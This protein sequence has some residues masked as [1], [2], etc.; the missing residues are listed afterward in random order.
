MAAV[1]KIFVGFGFGAIQ[2]GLF[3]Y[4]AFRSGKFERLV[5]AEVVP[6]LV[7]AIRRAK[8]CYRVNVATRTGIEVR[9]VHGVEIFNPTVPA[10][11][12]A[13]A[14]A[15][16]EATEIATALPSVEFFLRGEPS[17][18]GMIARAMQ[19]KAARQ[20]LPPSIV[21]T[22][23][24]HNHAAEILQAV[25]DQNLDPAARPAVR[26]RS[27]ILN[28]VIGKMSGMVTDP[29]EI[30]ADGLARLVDDFPRALLVE[31]FNRILITRIEL[32]GFRRGIEVFIEK[33]DLLPFEEAKLYGH[34]AVHALIGYLIQRRGHRF[35]SEAADDL[36]LMA[37]AREA[38]LEESGAA[39][40]ARH[41][42]LD[43]LFTPA[44]YQ[45]YADDLLARMTN[46]YLRDHTERVIRDPRRKLAWEDRLIG[47]MRFALD[48]GITPRRFA[49]GAA[50]ALETLGSP[51]SAADQ[52][53]ELWPA[54][55]EPSGRKA[56]LIRLITEAQAKLKTEQT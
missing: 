1:P 53:Q 9:K 7:A 38:F 22:A 51:K 31:E 13:L 46:P 48:A 20:D 32:P 41:R 21:Y 18:A 29:G 50:A 47:T 5:V 19:T 14:R 23:E 45:A 43:P 30:A 37:F 28:T 12:R 24:N 15:L 44:G 52:L 39:L 2:G 4:E 26:R 42:G 36:P 56:Q 3:L 11:E 55:D 17:V 27:Q 10:D 16:D 54:A 49:L 25:C 6:E 34:N 8:G 40:V 35:M 33:P